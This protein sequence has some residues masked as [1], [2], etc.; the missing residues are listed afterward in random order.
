[1][2]KI[3][4]YAM[5]VLLSINAAT[6]LRSDDDTSPYDF[7]KQELRKINSAN[8]Q[9]VQSNEPFAPLVNAFVANARDDDKA[10]TAY[11]QQFD[12]SIAPLFEQIINKQYD[13]TSK[14]ELKE[15]QN[16][17]SIAAN[18][19]N[20]YEVFK[21]L[22]EIQCEFEYCPY[23]SNANPMLLS[24]FSFS[25]IASQI[26]PRKAYETCYDITTFYP[27]CN[28]LNYHEYTEDESPAKLS[29]AVNYA[30]NPLKYY[31]EILNQYKARNQK[32]EPQEVAE[33]KK[34]VSPEGDWTWEE[35]VTFMEYNPQ[36]AYET[37]KNANTLTEKLQLAMFLQAYFPEKNKEIKDNLRE[38]VKAFG[39]DKKYKD[40]SR[41]YNKEEFQQKFANELAENDTPIS[42]EYLVEV[43]T[44]AS[45]KSLVDTQFAELYC[46]VAKKMPEIIVVTAPYFGGNRDNFVPR[47]AC[48]YDYDYKQF[49]FQALY[50]YIDLTEQADGY[51][52]SK[53]EGTARFFHQRQQAFTVDSGFLGI[54][55]ENPKKYNLKYPYEAWSYVSLENRKVFDKIKQSYLETQKILM[56][57]FINN[58]KFSEEKAQLVTENLLFTAPF[59][60]RCEYDEIPL[61]L[62]TLMIENKPLNEVKYFILSPNFLEQQK[63][64]MDFYNKAPL[65][66]IAVQNPDY[67][68]L[69]TEITENMSAED[70]K[71]YD[72]ESN[73]NARNNINKTPLM[74][75]AQFNLTESAKFLINAGADVNAVTQTEKYWGLSRDN[76]TALMYAAE[77]ADLDMIK[78][79]LDNGADKNMVD[80]KG[81]RAVDY[82]MGFASGNY[83]QK[84]SDEDFK[85]A[86]S[87]LL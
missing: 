69:L 46:G 45:D 77:N 71:Q 54:V 9:Y 38:V 16:K 22:D 86:L 82:L 1:M 48:Y 52:L 81:Y 84:L 24:A 4:F 14:K 76:R 80:T 30:Q 34:P 68:K 49:P 63:N 6:A 44:T 29:S 83:N 3:I 59:G 50:E 75:A 12:K 15:T 56:D 26:K 28:T 39:D 2:K 20:L 61:N 87:L 62:R 47:L 10:Q 66:H 79:L 32:E 41:R 13:D 18:N 58:R 85:Q 55:P 27:T 78:L 35:A 21:I 40:Y 74:V 51:F 72:L 65:I 42:K 25:K 23:Y 60:T 19:G 73:V 37:F 33:L 8:A 64:Q 36:K 53:H 43:F 11:L 5:S 7:A 31:T 70:Q 17:L 67:L 57:Y